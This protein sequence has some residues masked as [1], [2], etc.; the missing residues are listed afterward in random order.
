MSDRPAPKFR[1]IASGVTIQ[2]SRI[3]VASSY[4]LG[5]AIR[6]ASQLKLRGL[7]SYCQLLAFPPDLRGVEPRRATRASASPSNPVRP[8]AHPHIKTDPT[9]VKVRG[10]R[11][12]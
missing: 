7:A 1:L 11:F 3:C 12:V 8:Q 5:Q 9:I 6:E 2:L 4:R 10:T